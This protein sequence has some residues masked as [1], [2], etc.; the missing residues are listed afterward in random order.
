[1]KLVMLLT[2][3]L[4][5]FANNNRNLD[6]NRMGLSNRTTWIS[7]NPA[8]LFGPPVFEECQVSVKEG[9][10]TVVNISLK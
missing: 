6:F 10:E 3:F 4:I 9:E 8:I 5:L 1:M 7:N 2:A